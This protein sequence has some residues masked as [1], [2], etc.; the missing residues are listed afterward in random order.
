MIDVIKQGAQA[1]AL[2]WP[3]T[4]GMHAIDARPHCEA[5]G[6]L[7]VR[8]H[9]AGDGAELVVLAPDDWVPPYQSAEGSYQLPVAHAVPDFRDPGTR[10]HL[11][12]VV[13]E[14]YGAAVWVRWWWRGPVMDGI[15]AWCEV[16]DIRGRRLLAGPAVK[17][18]TEVAAL[19]AAM[20]AAP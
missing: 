19:L 18:R 2:G 1:V 10:G 9:G 20:E 8:I 5:G 17:H 15:A 3:W 11:L 4:P 7:V 16:V 12:Q 14:R 13:R 6:W